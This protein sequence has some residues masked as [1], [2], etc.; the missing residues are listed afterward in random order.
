MRARRCGAG[1]R[2]CRRCGCSPPPPAPP[3]PCCRRSCTTARPGHCSSRL[4][5]AGGGEHTGG[6]VVPR[7][8]PWPPQ[9]QGSMSP[10]VWGQPGGA[11]CCWGARPS[12]TP[13]LAWLQR[14]P[15]CPLCPGS[16]ALCPVA[17]PLHL[18]P[19]RRGLPHTITLC[20][21]LCTPCCAP[22]HKSSPVPPNL[23]LYPMAYPLQCP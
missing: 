11:G 10:M 13:A 1:R 9:A 22:W 15:A 20:N 17:Y 3:P 8:L 21:A 19:Q 2:G 4:G 14:H 18:S 23:M 5:M 6:E 16:P 12:A 7:A